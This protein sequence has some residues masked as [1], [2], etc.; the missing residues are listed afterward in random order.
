MANVRKAKKALRQS[1]KRR[2]HNKRIKDRAKRWIK[3]FNDLLNAGELDRAREIIP[4]VQKY[5]DKAA[6]RNIFHKNKA[7]RLVRKL[8]VRLNA[9]K[10]G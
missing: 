3:K 5:I 6:K 1:L 10:Q 8:Y 4:K 9:V 7:A 2:E